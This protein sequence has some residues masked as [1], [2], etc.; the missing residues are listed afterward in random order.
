MASKIALNLILSLVW[1]FLQNDWTLAGFIVGYVLGALVLV[2]FRRFFPAPLYLLKV[3]AVVKLLALFIKE[4]LLSGFTVAR[5]TVAPKLTVRPGI[6]A[7]RTEL[8]SDWEVTLLACLICLTPGTLTLDVSDD[9]GTLF[10]HAMD[11]GDAEQI[12]EQIRHTFEKA[13]MEV[14]RS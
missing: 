10:I 7:F 5:Q 14:S 12:S 11:I 6:F 2:V 1:M 9:K 4:L 8:K 3:W 13:I